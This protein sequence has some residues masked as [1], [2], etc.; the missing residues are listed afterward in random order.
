MIFYPAYP[1]QQSSTLA[2][3]GSAIHAAL[4]MLQSA[5]W[6]ADSRRG[7]MR[8]VPGDIPLIAGRKGRCAAAPLREAL[9]ITLDWCLDNGVARAAG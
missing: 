5:P 1:M 6:P 2:A 3:P 4:Q 9:S 7:E 8:R